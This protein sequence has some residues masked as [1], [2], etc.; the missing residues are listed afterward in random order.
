MRAL[1]K[2]DSWSDDDKLRKL[3]MIIFQVIDRQLSSTFWQNNLVI[4]DNFARSCN[5]SFVS[6]NRS[7]ISCTV[8]VDGI[9]NSYFILKLRISYQN[10]SRNSWALFVRNRRSDPPVLVP[11]F[12][13][14]ILI[15]RGGGGDPNPAA[16]GGLITWNFDFIWN[17][18]QTSGVP[19]P[20]KSAPPPRPP[21]GGTSKNTDC[22]SGNP[23][24]QCVQFSELVVHWDNLRPSTGRW[25]SN[26][27]KIRWILGF[28][29]VI[30]RNKS[31]AT[32]RWQLLHGLKFS[33]GNFEDSRPGE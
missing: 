13:F 12:F 24:I 18:N 21:V 11:V 17:S 4:L 20:A 30:L 6:W 16:F 9:W 27:I 23:A 31:D 33:V 15:W 22:I 25:I 7:K 3:G 1:S 14:W 2:Q 29:K 19:C 5:I 8:P 28:E 10:H 26:W 32:Q